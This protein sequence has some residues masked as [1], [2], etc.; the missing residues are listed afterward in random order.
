MFKCLRAALFI[1]LMS[2]C[3]N[4]TTTLRVEL[5]KVKNGYS[6]PVSRFAWYS[7]NA[8]GMRQLCSDKKGSPS[9]LEPALLVVSDEVMWM[10]KRLKVDWAKVAKGDDLKIQP[11]YEAVA[12]RVNQEQELRSACKREEKTIIAAVA[13]DANISSQLAPRVDYTMSA[14]GVDTV[15]FLVDGVGAPRTPQEVDVKNIQI[16]STSSGFILE[17]EN[18]RSSRTYTKLPSFL[19]EVKPPQVEIKVSHLQSFGVL[20]HTIDELAAAGVYCAKPIWDKYLVSKTTRDSLAVATYA[21]EYDSLSMSDHVT[22]HFLRG[23]IHIPGQATSRMD[24]V[25]CPIKDIKPISTAQCPPINTPSESKLPTNSSLTDS[26]DEEKLQEAFAE[27]PSTNEPSLRGNVQLDEMEV[28]GDGRLLSPSEIKRVIGHRSSLL[29]ACYDQTLKN[30]P[31]LNGSIK[32]KFTIEPSGR[33]SERRILEDELRSTT[34][35][36]C[37]LRKIEG[38]RFSHFEG[39]SLTVLQSFT[40]TP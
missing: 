8:Q 29:R 11:I 5:P 18:Q 10:G 4:E 7:D 37:L 27:L 13:M 25:S 21:K 36:I 39:E 9:K 28:L 2:G 33:V 12:A 34:L 38:F 26:M 15:M 31:R 22:V 40:F 1:V 17:Y 24:G 6:V 23:P 35:N 16:S 32:I 19:G 20:I 3:Q 30:T 14:A